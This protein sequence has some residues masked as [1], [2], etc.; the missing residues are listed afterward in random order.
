MFT[1]VIDPKKEFQTQYSKN[2]KKRP[3]EVVLI[4]DN[5]I[6][7]KK[8]CT[9][10]T[11]S[12]KL[13]QWIYFKIGEKRY[14]QLHQFLQTKSFHELHGKK[15]S[16]ELFDQTEWTPEC[17]DLKHLIEEY[18]NINL[19]KKHKICFEFTSKHPDFIPFINS[20]GY[21]LKKERY[22]Y[23]IQNKSLKDPLKVKEEVRSKILEYI[24]YHPESYYKDE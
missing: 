23:T 22:K 19:P 11:K 3:D 2:F 21:P 20:L 18:S 17:L 8:R 6:L 14:R 16:P 13:D 9:H 5:K 7:D 24:K 12:Y 10:I 1:N 4:E 15:L